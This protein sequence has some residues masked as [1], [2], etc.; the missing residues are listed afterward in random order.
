MESVCLYSLVMAQLILVSQSQRDQ[1]RRSADQSVVKFEYGEQSHKLLKSNGHAVEFHAY[2]GMPHS[3]CQEELEDLAQWL[4][5]R[6]DSS[7]V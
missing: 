1:M 5:K 7:K 4:E 2:Q 6:L 3:A